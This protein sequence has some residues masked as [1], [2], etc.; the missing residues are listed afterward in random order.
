MTPFWFFHYFGVT[1][2][3]L[4]IAAA[5]VVVDVDTVLNAAAVVDVVAVVKKIW[6][7]LEQLQMFLSC[8]L[9][10]DY[11]KVLFR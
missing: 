11:K 1:R 4:V 6:R 8:L 2:R 7:C 3:H 9:E 5:A 10:V